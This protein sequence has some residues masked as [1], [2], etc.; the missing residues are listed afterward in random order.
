MVVK[1]TLSSLIHGYR[2]HA[3][4][5]GKEWLRIL[6]I[7]I[8]FGFI[9]SFTLWNDPETPEI[10]NLI[11]GIFNWVLYSIFSFLGILAMH[12]PM[13]IMAYK[14]GYRMN[15]KQ[16][17]LG[18]ILNLFFCFLSAGTIIFLTPPSAN[19]TTK[20]NERVGYFSPGPQHREFGYLVFW[21]VF[22][23]VLYSVLLKLILPFNLAIDLIMVGILISMWS[24]FPVDFVFKI[25]DKN[26][27]ISNGTYFILGMQTF[28]VFGVAFY[29]LSI[30]SIFYL[31]RLWAIIIPLIL[32]I[33]VY[34]IYYVFVM[35]NGKDKGGKMNPR[36]LWRQ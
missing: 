13:R 16:W 10:F 18:L 36:G 22:G 19:I 27:P 26:T 33:I 14:M 4:I 1:H 17:N 5:T 28:I 35:S 15:L 23:T 31:P 29:V 9:F 25:F 11:F 8:I 3:S 2:R 6:T 7:A 20:I 34:L 32:A 30:L 21:G 24:F 12:V